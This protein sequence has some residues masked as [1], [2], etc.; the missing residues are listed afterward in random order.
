M[1]SVLLNLLSLILWPNTWF[2]LE[3]FPV[4]IW[5]KMCILL[6]LGGVFCR[7]LWGLVVYSAVQAFYFLARGL[8]HCS[9]HYVKWSIEILSCYYWI[10]HFS[11]N[12]VSF[13]FTNFGAL[14]LGAYKFRV[15]MSSCWID[16][17]TI[18][19]CSS[20]C[21]GTALFEFL[22]DAVIGNFTPMLK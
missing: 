1:V 22:N 8:S 2:I 19:M 17:F 10:V 18:I 6:F 13:C 11:L 20:L 21:R 3:N 5:E 16:T 4:C 15:V 9:I 7:C 12:S 14:L